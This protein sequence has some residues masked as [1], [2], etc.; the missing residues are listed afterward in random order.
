LRLGLG[1]WLRQE[2]RLWLGLVETR[3]KIVVE[4]RVKVRVRIVV[5]TIII[6]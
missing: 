3:A 5:E 4:T 1:L 6:L 2:L